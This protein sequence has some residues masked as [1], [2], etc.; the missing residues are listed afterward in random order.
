MSSEFTKSQVAERYARLCRS[1]IQLSDRFQKLDV[2][3]MS[4]KSKLI[5]LLKALKHYKL[6]LQQ[7]EDDKLSLQQQIATLTEKCEKLQEFEA[8]SQPDMESELSEAEH[9]IT[10]VEETIE[11]M[12][13]DSSPDLSPAEKKLLDDYFLNPD[14]FTLLD[15]DSPSLELDPLLSQ[16]KLLHVQEL[17]H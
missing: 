1:Y 16:E 6:L 15:F 5:P 17:G 8:F 12:D 9:H 14:E 4:L 3:H 2:E 13:S 11:E 10:L 7:L